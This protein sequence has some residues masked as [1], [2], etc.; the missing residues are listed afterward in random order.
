MDNACL[1]Q[2][3]GTKVDR[4]YSVNLFCLFVKKVIHKLLYL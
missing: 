4:S 2:A 1:Y 3:G